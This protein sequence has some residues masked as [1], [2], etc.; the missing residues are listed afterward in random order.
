MSHNFKDLIIN[1]KS[2]PKS[3]VCYLI[4]CGLFC[5]ACLS[6]Q[7]PNSEKTQI[8]INSKQIGLMTET[9]QKAINSCAEK[10]GGVVIFPAGTY[11]CGGIQ[12][13]SHV[14]LQLEKGALL[15]G[16]DKYIDYQNDAF[17]YGMRIVYITAAVICM[18]GAILT[19][20]RLFGKKA[21]I[22]D[23]IELENVENL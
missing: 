11:L 21:K 15:K 14:S 16:S 7:Y 12:L 20:L 10:G 2:K 17:I 13:K 5:V 19:A 3:K 9:I 1:I 6:M 8:T 18:I 23:A 4:G 22:E